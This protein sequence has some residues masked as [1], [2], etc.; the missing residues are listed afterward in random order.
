MV[1][2]VFPQ[3]GRGVGLSM[4]VFCLGKISESLYRKGAL[5]TV[6]N[7]KSKALVHAE[8][9]NVMILQGELIRSR[10]STRLMSRT[11]RRVS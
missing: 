5:K 11:P 3:D 9:A 10:F 1:R 6:K 4:R 7:K 8:Y 2:A